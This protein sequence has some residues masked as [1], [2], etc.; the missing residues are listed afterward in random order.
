MT[1][2]LRYAF[3]LIGLALLTTAHAA[4]Y[5][6]GGAGCTHPSIAEA[7]VEAERSPGADTIR[8]SRMLNYTE[9]QI[10]FSTGQELEIAGG[11]ETCGSDQS[12][13]TGMGGGARVLNS[14]WP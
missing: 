6:V 14:A 8:L 4:T 1:A 2:I 7:L 10:S 9:Q 3:G 13:N 11:Y 12:G 5:T